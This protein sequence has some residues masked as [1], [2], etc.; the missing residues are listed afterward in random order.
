M[1]WIHFHVAEKGKVKVCCI[2][3]IPFGNINENSLEEIWNG[4]PIQ[5][6]REKFLKGEKDN[7]CAGCFKIEQG[8]GTSIRQETFDKFPEINPAEIILGEKP[9]YFDIRF[10]NVCN[11]R[12]RTCWH[13]A[14]SK[15]FKEAKELKT[16]FGNS[17]IIKNINDFDVF[18]SKMGDSLLQAKEIYFAGGEPLV[19]EEHYLLLDWL[20]KNKVLNVKLRYNTNFSVLEFKQYKVLDYWRKFKNIEILAS[21]D[22]TEKLGEY[23]RKEF[24]WKVFL[25][26]RKTLNYIPN[27]DFKITPTVSVFNIKKLPYLYKKSIELHTIEGNDFY[28]NLLERP[29]YYN[30]KII[31]PSDK[32]K[33]SREYEEF[34]IWLDENVSGNTSIKNQFKECI[35]FMNSE[36]LHDKYWGKF[37]EETLKLDEMR[38]ENFNLVQ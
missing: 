16:N 12:C 22:A 30:V 11:F 25:E 19:T 28:V 36:N 18:I 21:I 6:L 4:K 10:S 32:L 8:G 23:I 37:K 7:R 5:V 38:G 1:P 20:L 26:N 2:A 35:S 24:D 29:F 15:W 17:A 33:I 3:N 14:S 9:I 13:G 34:Y 27:V 31:S